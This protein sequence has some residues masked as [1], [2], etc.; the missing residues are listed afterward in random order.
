MAKRRKLFVPRSAVKPYV[1]QQVRTGL[2]RATRMG[3]QYATAKAKE[4]FDNQI[5]GKTISDVG[6]LL[7]GQAEKLKS[8]I[9]TEGKNFNK[10]KMQ[11]LNTTAVG[12]TSESTC[13]FSYRPKKTRKTED[14]IYYEALRNKTVTLTNVAGFQSV[15]DRNLALLEPP[16]GDN[17]TA[18]NSYTNFSIRN[19]FDRML[20]AR[21][22]Q[23]TAGTARDLPTQSMVANFHQLQS[24]MIITAPAGGAIVDIY[25]LQP[26]FGI[27]PGTWQSETYASDH[28]GPQWCFL[29][30]ISANT[31]VETMDN[32]DHTTIGA[33][34]MDSV[35]FRRTY[36][37]IKKTTVRMSANSIHRHRHVFGIN[38][39]V[40][41][42]E[43]GQASA[44]GGT[45]P[46][47]PT[48]M[49]IHRGYPSSTS[50]A[51]AATITV[52][53]ESKLYYSSR[54]GS[55]SKVIVYNNN[56]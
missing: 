32:L 29:N 4:V 51:E 8:P 18:D 16:S 49:V 47:L 31:V 45:C 54:L 55:T 22:I 36:N 5:A 17:L 50:L 41:W 12:E 44:N 21:T 10:D 19:E 11:L 35:T 48:Q 9:G 23:G 53:Q 38:K 33:D 34:P 40:T 30:G 15:A 52:Q 43:M 42:D 37:L 7:Q 26:K 6:V 13:V 56:T 24:T 39:S 2:K 1:R 27:G 3:A 20:R 14:T 25:D 28:I 46:W